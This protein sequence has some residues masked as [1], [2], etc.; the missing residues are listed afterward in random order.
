MNN[1]L[2]LSEFWY[3]CQRIKSSCSFMLSKWWS[4]EDF[5][6]PHTKSQAAS[7]ARESEGKEDNLPSFCVTLQYSSFLKLHLPF[8]KQETLPSPS[9]SENSSGPWPIP[10]ISVSSSEW[11]KGFKFSVWK[12]T[13]QWLLQNAIVAIFTLRSQSQLWRERFLVEFSLS[14][15]SNQYRNKFFLSL[16]FV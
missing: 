7:K 15:A 4:K 10:H 14:V 9:Y 13:L 16:R 5:T 6:H 3:V 12:V 11:V 2:C 8:S 1:T